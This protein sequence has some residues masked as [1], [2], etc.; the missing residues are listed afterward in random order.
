MRKH[1][2]NAGPCKLSDS[3]LENTSKAVLEL[4]NCGQSILEV[5]HRGKEFMA[6]MDETIAM[7]HE[8]MN[9]PDD[10]EILFLGGGASLQFAMI[11]YNFLQG[12]AFYLNTGTWS[13]KAVQE[14]ALW[15]DVVEVS[16]KD[17]G[18]TYIPKD[19]HITSD[20]DYAH[21][22]TNN[23]IKGTEILTDIDCPVPLIADMSSD[24]MSRPVDFSKY[25]LV[26]G[27]AQKNVGPAGATFVIIRKS[28]L[29]KVVNRPIPSMLKY[30]THIESGSMY[31]TPPVINVYA[32]RETLKWVKSMGG[33]QA[34]DKLAQDRAD[35]LYNAIDESNMF[36]GTVAKED[37]SRMNICFIMEDKYEA[38]QADFI[39]F[40]GER[41]IVGIKGHRSVGGFRASTYN[42]STME[43]VQALV[44]AMREF[45]KANA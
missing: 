12:K 37:R 11:P 29:D 18:F 15:G 23:T 3:L 24:F 35:L 14:A 10:F 30:S 22:T 20:M 5:S 39:K 26:Y 41:N 32:I 19:F 2:F 13:T 44:N 17:K 21:I 36:K 16:S 4:D 38:L 43:D 31:N 45:E 7:M 28:M 42:A 25:A 1:I 9:I 34:M 6:I 8:V 40:A 27:G 33:I